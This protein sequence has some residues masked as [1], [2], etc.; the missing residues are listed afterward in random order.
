MTNNSRIMQVRSVL[1]RSGHNLF[2]KNT[3]F[4]CNR[5]EGPGSPVLCS[6]MMVLS[7]FTGSYDS[8]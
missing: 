5:F 8:L 6:Y 2:I 4:F 7:S 1:I 3:R